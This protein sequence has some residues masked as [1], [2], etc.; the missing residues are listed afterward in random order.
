MRIALLGGVPA[1]LGG[2]GLEIQMRRT[3]EALAARGHEVFAVAQAAEARPFDVLH[4]FGADGDVWHA[5]HHWR[6]NPAPLVVSPV[7]VVAPGAAE[8]RQVLGARLP[9]PAFGPRLRAEVLRRATCAIALTD[10]EAG[11]IER[12]VKPATVAVETIPNG[13]DP[14]PSG[15]SEEGLPSGYVLLLGA[16]STRKR[17]AQTVEAL[18]RAGVPVVVAGGFDGSSQERADFEATVARAGESALWLGEI[19]DRARLAGLLRGARALVHLSAAEGQSL[20]VLEALSVGTP[21]LLSPLPA[22]RELAARFPAHVRLVESPDD[23]ARSLADAGGP[24]GPAS[25]PT[26]DDVAERLEGVY[27]ALG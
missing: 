25:L 15:G 5:L 9:I 7:V 22:N 8:R 10:H 17:Q 1:S 13:V 11:L 26:W 23:L 16:V 24:L 19:R 12:L 27:S 6:L 4:A 21:A 20:A 3:G 2:G 18:A 14:L